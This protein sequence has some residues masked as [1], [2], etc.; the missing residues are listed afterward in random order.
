M[1][2]LH[3]RA[4]RRGSAAGLTRALRCPETENV[5]VVVYMDDSDVEGDGRREVLKLGDCGEARRYVPGQMYATNVGTPEFM[6]PEV[7]QCTACA[8]R[9]ATDADARVLLARGPGGVDR[10]HT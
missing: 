5:F 8:R 2:P 3:A 4:F 7:S 9:W 6:A 10:R 1:P